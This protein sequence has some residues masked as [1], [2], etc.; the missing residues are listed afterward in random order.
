MR[1]K[2]CPSLP[3]PH[4]VAIPSTRRFLHR[5][6]F[7]E[8]PMIS[9]VAAHVGLG[10][11]Q[12]TMGEERHSHMSLYDHRGSISTDRTSGSQER[13]DILQEMD[14]VMPEPPQKQVRLPVRPKGT[15]RL[16]D[17]IIQRTLGTGS[18]GRVHLGMCSHPG[19][20]LRLTFGIVRSKHNLRFYAIKVLNKE[21][22]VR[23]KQIEH[24]NNEQQMLA[25]VQ[26][27]F[28]IN[29][30]GVFQDSGNLYMVMDFVPGGELFT[31]LRRSNVCTFHSVF[32]LII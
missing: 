23:M 15:Y 21:R 24:T 2:G 30:W 5:L 17:F 26:H 8:T 19:R 31:L 25:S 29:L 7:T 10:T 16:S 20:C 12:Q 11:K 13:S 9:K 28:I 1:A 18:F 6:S 4:I 3:R 14:D 32:G 22:I 27:P